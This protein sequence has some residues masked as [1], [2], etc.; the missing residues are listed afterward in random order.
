MARFSPDIMRRR[1]DDVPPWLDVFDLGQILIWMLDE[2][3]PKAHWQRPIAWNHAVYD[4]AIPQA[5]EQSIKALTASCSYQVSGP[6]NGLET[7]HLI[8]ALFPPEV[9]LEGSGI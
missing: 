9:P 4:P 3:A 2:E 5:R 1:L 8:D 6:A 7:L